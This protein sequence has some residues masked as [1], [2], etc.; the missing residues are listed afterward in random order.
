MTK[1]EIQTTFEI[2]NKMSRMTRDVQA[3]IVDK[4]NSFED[5]LEIF[6]TTPVALQWHDS[7]ILHLH[8]FE[9][10]HGRIDWFDDGWRHRHQDVD[11]VE[12]V[13]DKESYFEEWS[14]EKFRDFQEA[15]LNHGSHSFTLDW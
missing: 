4:S 2:V 15:V 5:R 9:K 7:W 6:T 12:L 3:F 14:D 13:K 10:K 8:E 1:E 11:L